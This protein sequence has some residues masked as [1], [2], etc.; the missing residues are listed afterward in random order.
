MTCFTTNINPLLLL[1][2]Q[3]FQPGRAF[4]RS[5]EIP[6]SSEEKVSFNMPSVDREIKVVSN[7]HKTAPTFHHSCMALAIRRQLSQQ[8]TPDNGALATTEVA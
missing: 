3:R 5:K 8:T 7:H 6:Q 1:P 2:S 4:L